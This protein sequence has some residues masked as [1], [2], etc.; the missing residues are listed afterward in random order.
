MQPLGGPGRGLEK[1]SAGEGGVPERI[2]MRAQ[3]GAYRAALAEAVLPQ[4]CSPPASGLAGGGA[5]CGHWAAAA[6]AGL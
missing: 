5:E 1:R 6:A 2:T 4:G 3:P